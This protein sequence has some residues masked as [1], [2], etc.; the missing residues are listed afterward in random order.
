MFVTVPQYELQ[1]PEPLS[2]PEDRH[3]GAVNLVCDVPWFLF[4]YA[5]DYGPVKLRHTSAVTW[6]PT[7]VELLALVPPELRGGLALF[8]RSDEQQHPWRLNWVDALWAA[9]DQDDAAGK[10]LV[11]LAGEKCLR[12]PSLERVPRHVGYRLVYECPRQAVSQTGRA[13]PPRNEGA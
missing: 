3:W 6:A 10:L 12:A 13:H 2:A 11:R 5:V 9:D 4:T 8:S 1:L 7:L